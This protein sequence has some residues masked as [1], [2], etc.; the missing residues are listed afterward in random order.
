VLEILGFVLMVPGLITIYRA[1][2]IADK[3]RIYEKVECNF[4][5]EL[6][7]K[8][9]TEFKNNRAILIVKIIGM[10]MLLPGLIWIIIA[11]SIK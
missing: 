5:E 7:E 1:K 11:L 2:M 8:E 10:M 9:L 3:Y 4:E 6:N